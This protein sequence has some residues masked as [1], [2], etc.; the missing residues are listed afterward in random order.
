MVAAKFEPTENW[1]PPGYVIR[2]EGAYKGLNVRISSSF[3][4]VDAAASHATA[5][6]ATAPATSKQREHFKFK[7]AI[8]KILLGVILVFSGVGVR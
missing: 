3:C 1:L 2:K 7:K 8:F 5:E 6:T 4:A